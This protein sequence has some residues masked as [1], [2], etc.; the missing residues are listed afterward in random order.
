MDVFLL[1][2]AVLRLGC[3]GSWILSK[4]G[5]CKSMASKSKHYSFVKLLKVF[6]RQASQDFVGLPGPVLRKRKEYLQ[7]FLEGWL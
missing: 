7:I 5:I 4:F 6:G 2:L 1:K 3:I